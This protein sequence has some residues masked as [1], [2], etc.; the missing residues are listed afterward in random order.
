MINNG[1]YGF[2]AL[3]YQNCRAVSIVVKHEAL[4]GW[5]FQWT[6]ID[7]IVNSGREYLMEIQGSLSKTECEITKNN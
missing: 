6:F 4:D 1:C 7:R 3:E 5:H 2:T